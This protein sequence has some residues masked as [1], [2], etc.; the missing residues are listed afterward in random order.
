MGTWG[1]GPFDNDTAAD[2]CGDLDDADPAERVE[3]IRETLAG[4][5]EELGYL[6]R[7]GADQAVAAA[8]VV[9]SQL[10]GAERVTSPYAPT[11][12]TDGERIDVPPDLPALAVRALD[13]VVEDDSEWRDLWEDSDEAEAAFAAVK[14]LRDVLSR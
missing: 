11:F 9:A 4:A 7:D 10:P 5:A 3:M 6:D 12:L 8:A 2:W 14:Q 1:T 13:R